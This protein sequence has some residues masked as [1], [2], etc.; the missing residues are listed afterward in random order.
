[1]VSSD[2]SLVRRILSGEEAAFDEFFEEHFPRLYRF[3]VARM[4]RDADAAEDVV[5]ATLCAAIGKLATYRGEAPV[6]TWL[7]TFCR[8]EIASYFARARR[9]PPSVDLAEDD[10]EMAGAL[11]SLWALAGEGPEQA[12]RRREIERLVHVA[13]DHLPRHY[14]DALEWKYT[15]G[16][17]V[18][19]I[20]SRLGV[21]SKAA[22]SLLTRAREAFRDGFSTLVSR[23]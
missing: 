10:V 7:C 15:E 14:A 11:Q 1:V 19:E 2:R 13:L 21:S 17:P 6:F 8:H 12:V 5:Q 22:E 3:A 16:L 4:G 23:S 18:V 9:Q 20:A